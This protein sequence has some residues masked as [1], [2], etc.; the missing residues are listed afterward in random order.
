MTIINVNNPR[1]NITGIAFISPFAKRNW[2]QVDE[3]YSNLFKIPLKVVRP[4]IR[5]HEYNTEKIFGKIFNEIEYSIDLP[6][7]FDSNDTKIIIG[8]T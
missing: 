1:G 8:K 4:T 6:R 5:L 7:F 3:T 2:V